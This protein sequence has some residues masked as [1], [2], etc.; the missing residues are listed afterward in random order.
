M[1]EQNKRRHPRLAHRARINVFISPSRSMVVQMQDFS[2]GGL[3]LL[4]QDASLLTLG[5]VFEVQ[6]TEFPDAPIRQVKVVRIQD[7]VG[8]GVEFV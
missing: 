6:T 4:V 2:E 7:G 3:F 1:T 8:V 5:Q